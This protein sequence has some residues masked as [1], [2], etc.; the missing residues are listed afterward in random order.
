M[1]FFGLRGKR[2]AGLGPASRVAFGHRFATALS[3]S[4]PQ[5]YQGGLRQQGLGPAG[6][7]PPLTPA[8]GPLKI[9]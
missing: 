2:I 1:D 4:R 8:P 3:S 6:R 9:Q 7:E 5:R